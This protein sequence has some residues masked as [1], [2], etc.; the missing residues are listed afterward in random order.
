ML[1]HADVERALQRN[2]FAQ[3]LPYGA[4]GHRSRLTDEWLQTQRGARARHYILYR[5]SHQSVIAHL[6]MD[7]ALADCAALLQR[8]H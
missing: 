1:A 4:H 3:R 2:L 7:T 8:V 5:P 6:P